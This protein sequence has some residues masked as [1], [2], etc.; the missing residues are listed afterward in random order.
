VQ[1]WRVVGW[2]GFGLGLLGL[3]VVL[4][5][6][7]NVVSESFGDY[8]RECGSVVAQPPTALHGDYCQDRLHTRRE[9]SMIAALL[10]ATLLALG[11][12]TLGTVR[13]RSGEDGGGRRARATG[14]MSDPPKPPAGAPHG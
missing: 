5:V 9:I 13:W 6:A 12:I 7:T 2:A 4:V 1:A 10:G 8:S 11:T 14:S 3:L